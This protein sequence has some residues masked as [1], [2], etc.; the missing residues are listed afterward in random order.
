M[1][2]NKLHGSKK[3]T[4]S[5]TLISMVLGLFGVIILSFSLTYLP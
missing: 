2:R 4:N 5:I 1:N 3:N